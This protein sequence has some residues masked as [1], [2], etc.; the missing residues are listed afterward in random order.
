M[1]RSHHR[2]KHKQHLQQFRQS[3]DTNVSKAAS[4][5]KASATWI[6]GIAGL[7]LG[8]AIGYFATSGSGLWMAAGSLA[9]AAA[10]YFIGKKI[11]REKAA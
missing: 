8:F 2:K 1:A 7:A 6:F 3:H 9:G 4:K 10:G 11:D 5:T